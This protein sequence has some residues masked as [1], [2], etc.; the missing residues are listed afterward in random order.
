MK[1]SENQKKYRVLTGIFIIIFVLSG[2]ALTFNL[3]GQWKQEYKFKELS[4]SVN[5]AS[6]KEDKQA[7]KLDKA[8]IYFSLKERNSDFAG[9]ISIEGTPLDYPVMYTPENPEYYLQRNFDKEYSPYGTPFISAA[10]DSQL[11]CD[12]VII[13]GHYVKNGNIFGN[14]KNYTDKSYLEEHPIINFDTLTEFSQY[15]I[16]SVFITADS[17]DGFPYYQFITSEDKAEFD[18]FISDVKNLSIYDTGVSAAYGDRLLTLST[19][20]YSVKNGRLVLVAV[21]R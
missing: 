14:L 12:N 1:K 6:N 17:E 9:W 5:E 7:E 20:D 3:Y 8:D 21:K 13:Y 4:Q 19:C 15:E 2:S 11:K 18:K 16:L 10:C